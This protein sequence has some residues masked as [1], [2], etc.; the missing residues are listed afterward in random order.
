MSVVRTQL[1]IK[2]FNAMAPLGEVYLTEDLWID[3]AGQGGDGTQRRFDIDV[4]HLALSPGRAQPI[5][6]QCLN[7]L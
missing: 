3:K 4:E 1:R 2:L 5:R 6:R 7:S